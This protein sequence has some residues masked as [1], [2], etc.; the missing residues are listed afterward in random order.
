MVIFL[1]LG[2]IV[3]LLV[4]F[5]LMIFFVV[6]VVFCFCWFRG[7]VYVMMFFKIN[8]NLF[9]RICFYCLGLLGLVM[10]LGFFR[11]ILL[12]EYELF[13]L[14]KEFLKVRGFLNL[15]MVLRCRLGVELLLL[16]VFIVNIL[17]L[18]FLM[19]GGLILLGWVWCYYFEFDILCGDLV[20]ILML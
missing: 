3:G 12:V 1:L 13:W 18:G 15:V 6:M 9:F 7:R 2:W 10:L 16:L 11:W 14:K 5:G 19:G 20:K 17:F 8:V 4:E